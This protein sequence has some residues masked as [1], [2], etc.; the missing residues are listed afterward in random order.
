MF[1]F[2][3]FFYCGKKQTGVISNFTR[4]TDSK[5]LEKSHWMF[6]LNLCRLDRLMKKTEPAIFH[7]VTV[8]QLSSFL[9]ESVHEKSSDFSL[10]FL[11]PVY[12]NSIATK[13]GQPPKLGGLT[14]WPPLPPRC[15]RDRNQQTRRKH[16]PPQVIVSG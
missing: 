15:R 1:F 7:T 2:F 16:F 3:L 12:S 13:T 5:Q 14:R 10:H 11:R 8:S 4:A 9:A 6:L